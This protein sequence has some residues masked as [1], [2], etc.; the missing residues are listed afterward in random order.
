LEEKNVE[1]EQIILD[2]KRNQHKSNEY[3][4]INERGQIPTINDQGVIITESIAILHYLEHTYHNNNLMPKDR[5]QY[6]IAITR[7]GQFSTKLDY[8]SNNLFYKTKILNL[9]NEHIL[10]D[11]NEMKQE[12]TYW[13][14]Y[15]EN[16]YYF[17]GE[18]SLADIVV[19]PTIALCVHLG[20][21][22]DYKYPNLGRWYRLLKNRESIKKTWPS[23]LGR[24][25]F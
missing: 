13:D 10:D 17:A 12:L 15:L 23:Y 11:I 5:K 6:G 18:F 22:I 2:P 20:L 24:S 14:Y 1:Y 25:L 9:E 3:L 21:D 7:I 19:F 8:I 4:S 16:S